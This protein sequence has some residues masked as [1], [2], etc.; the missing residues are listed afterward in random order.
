MLVLFIRSNVIFPYPDTPCIQI[1]VWIQCD[2]SISRYSMHSDIS[3]NS[4]WFSHI[5]ILHAF[6]YQF[7]FN[8]IFPL[9]FRYQ[10]RFN[11]IFPLA[12]R[13]QLRFNVLKTSSLLNSWNFWRTL[14]E[15][16]Q[17]AFLFIYL[18]IYLFLYYSFIHLFIYVVTYSS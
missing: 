13:Y 17:N 4:M 6:R 3:L 9:A 12:F 2:F 7:E 8:V 5:P 15:R 18:S 14:R 10:L 1:S 16:I 11:V